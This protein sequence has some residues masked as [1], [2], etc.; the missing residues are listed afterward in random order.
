MG[1]HMR[2][3]LEGVQQALTIDTGAEYVIPRR[4][5]FRRDIESLRGDARRV[6]QGL[7]KNLEK[8]LHESSQA[9]SSR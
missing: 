7:Q 2:R 6:T 3:V 4:G 1:K 5:D 8:V 9:G